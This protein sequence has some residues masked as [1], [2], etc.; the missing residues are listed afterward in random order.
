MDPD[1]ARAEFALVT[2]QVS[3][4]FGLLVAGVGSLVRGLLGAGTAQVRAL[5]ED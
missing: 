2:R 5:L 1:E 4:G 3:R